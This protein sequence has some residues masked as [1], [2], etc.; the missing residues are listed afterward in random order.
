MRLYGGSDV[1]TILVAENIITAQTATLPQKG[2]AYAQ[3]PVLCSHP[4]WR[5]VAAH[6]EGTQMGLSDGY[7]GK[8][9][10]ARGI[11]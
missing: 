4:L 11:G 6:H 10:R 9:R 1:E 5:D 8:F 7:D 3:K 2:T